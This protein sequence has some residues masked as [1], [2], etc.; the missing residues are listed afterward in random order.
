[1]AVASFLQMCSCQERFLVMRTP[2]ILIG[3]L[4]SAPVPNLI[5]W[6]LLGL[7]LSPFTVNQRSACLR[8]C[9]AFLWVSSLVESLLGMVSFAY[10]QVFELG[11]LH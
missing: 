2:S 7:S 3:S 9:S 6:V 1:M 5:L 10:K 11:I 4:S 8:D